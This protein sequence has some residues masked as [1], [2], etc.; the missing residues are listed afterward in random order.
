[1]RQ[2]SRFPSSKFIP[3][4]APGNRGYTNSVRMPDTS[5]QEWNLTLEQQVGA[6]TTF[7]MAYVGNVGR[8]ETARFDGNQPIGATAGSSLLNILPY[9]SLGG[10][11]TVQGNVVNSNYNGLLITLNR[12][13]TNGFSLLA[14]Y[15]WSKALG[16]TSGDNDDIQN[17]YNLTSM[18]PQRMTSRRRSI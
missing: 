7:T 17:I 11:I 2:D 10:P 12:R 5:A 8:H 9:P 6:N 18:V 13:F 3:P 15:T 16:Y 4:P 14:N 1:L